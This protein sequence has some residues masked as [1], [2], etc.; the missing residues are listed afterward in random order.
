MHTARVATLARQGKLSIE[1]CARAERDAFFHRMMKK[2]G[3]G[4]VFLAHH[5]ED[6][7]E[8][9]LGNLC[10]G[11]S[12]HGLSGMA[13]SA[14]DREGLTK[15]RPLLEARREEVDGFVQAHQLAFREDSSNVSA[16]HRR[17]RFRH[18]ALPLLR[19]ICQRD[20]VE[21][22]V[23]GAR[24]AARV[25]AFLREYALR[26]AQEEGV[27]EAD[28]T[29]AITPGLK[30]AHPAVQARILRHWL[31]KLLKIK[32]V[33]SHEIEGVLGL[34]DNDGVAK[35][36]LPGSACVRRKAKRLFV[37]PAQPSAPGNAGPLTRGAT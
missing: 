2:H 28:Q 17:N 14:T 23:R 35:V 3:A 10:R 13:L 1:T 36:N 33:G 31:V 16:E 19:E 22:I 25:E 9:V 24:F 26:F 6:Q 8:T 20:V 5:A 18:E 29:L 30:A 37:E 15:L 27:W 32:G 4:F 21:I 11:T 7:A 12:L 34:L